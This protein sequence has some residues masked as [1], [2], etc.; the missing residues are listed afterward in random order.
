MPPE[1]IVQELVVI[2]S[3]AQTKKLKLDASLF[4]ILVKIKNLT[5]SVSSRVSCW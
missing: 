3:S 4:I 2:L 5:P 1:K